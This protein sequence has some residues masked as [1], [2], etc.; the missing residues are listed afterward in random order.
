MSISAKSTR[1]PMVG[2][3]QTM[4]AKLR[5]RE[6]GSLTT[7]AGG[8]PQYQFYRFNGAFD[9]RYAVGGNQPRYFDQLCAATLYQSFTV[10]RTDYRV[11]FRNRSASDVMVG[12]S[13][14][15]SEGTRWQ[16]GSQA[17]MYYDAENNLK[18]VRLL[19]GVGDGGDKNRTV[20]K[21]SYHLAKIL[22]IT[23]SK[24]Y[25]ELQYSGDFGADPAVTPMLAVVMSD[26]PNE[27][28]SGNTVDFEVELV[29]HIKFWNLAQTVPQS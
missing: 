11:S 14:S 1:L 21:G 26:D 5:H 8:L 7:G 13:I 18:T 2:F 4:I 6:Y 3:P 15:P 17:A 23:K 27:G 29:Y 25:A 20:F 9:P 10:Y 22:G 24:L 16:P 28:A 19:N 12:M